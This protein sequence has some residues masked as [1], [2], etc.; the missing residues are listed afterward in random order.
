MHFTVRCK[1]TFHREHQSNFQLLKIIY[2]NHVGK[3][4]FWSALVLFMCLHVQMQDYQGT[5][6]CEKANS[7]FKTFVSGRRPAIDQNIS[8]GKYVEFQ[9]WFI[10]LSPASFNYYKL[11]LLNLAVYQYPI[12]WE[13]YRRALKRTI[14]QASYEA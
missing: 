6:W 1:F 12:E 5:L 14:T 3:I 11:S 13:Y 4:M 10:W 9:I 8:G 7:K 2:N